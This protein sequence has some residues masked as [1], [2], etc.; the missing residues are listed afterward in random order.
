MKNYFYI[1]LI[2]LIFTSC[3]KEHDIF[4]PYKKD[5]L[6]VLESLKGENQYMVF[7][8]SGGIKI[9]EANG[10]IISVD[11]NSFSSTTDSVIIQWRQIN[12]TRKIIADRF[13]MIEKSNYLISP[14]TIIDFKFK[15][16]KEKK[17]SHCKT[18]I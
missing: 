6:A 5:K 14:T 13:T 15:D 4:Y 11:E 3:L 9:I 2:T 18:N 1:S 12:S 16:K 17:F 8:N 10:F 7:K